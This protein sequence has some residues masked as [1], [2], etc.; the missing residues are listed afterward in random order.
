MFGNV[1]VRMIKEE[2]NPELRGGSIGVYNEEFMN[3]LKVG[4]EYKV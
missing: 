2:S 3:I 4:D 1:L